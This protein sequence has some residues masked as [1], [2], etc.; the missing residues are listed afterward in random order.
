MAEV[1]ST[2][3]PREDVGRETLRNWLHK[4]REIHAATDSELSTFVMGTT[5]VA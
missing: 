3:R 4:Y 5:E 1:V 2:P